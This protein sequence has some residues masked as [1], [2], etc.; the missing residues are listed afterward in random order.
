MNRT[1]SQLAGDE[2]NLILG[3]FF[4]IQNS[5]WL[6]LRTVAGGRMCFSERADKPRVV[7]FL[8]FITSTRCKGKQKKVARRKSG[9]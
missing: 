5:H 6:A 8:V 1:A 3:N 7:V 2:M 9:P 4:H